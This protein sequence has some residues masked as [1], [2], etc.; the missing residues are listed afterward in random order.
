MYEKTLYKK[1]TKGK[2]RVLNIRTQND[3]LQ[4]ESGILNGNLVCY[5]KLC[6]GKN[7]GKSN[8]T[9]SSE[10]AE[11]EGKAIIKDKLTKGYFET[12]A[13]VDNEEVILPMLAH[14]YF[15]HI[16]KVNW[17]D[18]WYVQPKFDGMRCLAF[19][20]ANGNVTLTSRTGKEITTMTHICNELSKIKLDIILDG[21]LYVHGENFQENMK[22][23][24][25]YN[26]G[27]SEKIKFN[28]YDCVEKG[29]FQ[30][31]DLKIHSILRSGLKFDSV[32]GVRTYACLDLESLG[33]FHQKFLEQGYEGTMLRKR[34]SEYKINGRS[35]E[36]LKYK[37]FKDLALPI[38][39]IVP[40]DSDPTMGSPVYHW[41]G[42][43]GHK[44]GPNI[45]GSG[46]RASHDKRR[47]MLLNKQN[48]IGK[49]YEVRFF[50]Y[51]DRGVPRFPITIGE[52]LDK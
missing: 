25:K 10:Q 7:I 44:L 41:L 31:R 19:V 3:I 17:R 46:I 32:I 12:I 13:E 1:D 18:N 37:D 50:E 36:L 22:Y 27:L 21:E 33:L 5:N 2:I 8:E 45:L 51:S 29:T 49:T 30:D 40:D 24:K 28:V 39:D 47:E 43:L 34:N 11:L 23:I 14:D 35:H 48:Y 26:K 4:Q 9:S 16:K 15:K 42:A 52:R 20:T 38:L 6:K